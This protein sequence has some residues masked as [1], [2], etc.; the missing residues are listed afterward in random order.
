MA[1]AWKTF[2]STE[3]WFRRGNSLI[4]GHRPL[5][6]QRSRSAFALEWVLLPHCGLPLRR[7]STRS[8]SATSSSA[9]CGHRKVAR[10]WLAAQAFRDARH[11]RRLQPAG[12]SPAAGASSAGITSAR[13]SVRGDEGR[14]MPGYRQN[15]VRFRCVSRRPSISV[16]RGEGHLPCSR[17]PKARSS[18]KTAWHLANTD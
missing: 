14:G 9:M 6:T 16:A 13:P 12:I 4:V 3:L 18:P 5:S 10:V 8:E 2:G 15:R 1:G 17:R 11:W 7:N